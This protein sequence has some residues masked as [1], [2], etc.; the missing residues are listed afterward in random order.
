M[1]CK[2]SIITATYNNAS[3][4]ADCLDCVKS[5]GG[6]IEH[7]IVDGVSS[8][9]T[10][11]IVKRYSHVSKVI[12]GRDRGIY[13]AMNKGLAMATGKVVGILN[14]D[15]FYA[16]ERVLAKVA[17]V[18]ADPA[19]DSCYGDLVYVNPDDTGKIIRHWRSGSFNRQSFYWGWMPPH[20]TFFVRRQLYENY[21][22]FNLN[23]GSAADYE[24]MLRFLFKHKITTAYIPEVLVKM[25]AGGIS[26][27]TLKNRLEANRMDR[28]AWKINGLKP[29][30]WTLYLKP[31][32]KIWQYIQP[33]FKSYKY[34]VS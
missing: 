16:N 4:V 12:S 23:L 25:R 34:Q 2:F 13:D 29:F 9:S 18:F 3:T 24:L 15:D 32:R 28:V 20:P 6:H 11:E 8:D 22:M 26:N 10:L 5:Q 27:A 30:P 1:S 31:L 21:G 14:A 7:I 33:N 17:E 19:I